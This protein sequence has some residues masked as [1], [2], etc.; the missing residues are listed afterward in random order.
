MVAKIDNDSFNSILADGSRDKSNREQEIIYICMLQ[1][2]KHVIQFVTLVSIP[3][4]N[5]ENITA[6]IINTLTRK[7]QLKKWTN[8]VIM[9]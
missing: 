6:E 3:K 7:L 5:A 2:N 1:E 4:A 9:Y 8:N